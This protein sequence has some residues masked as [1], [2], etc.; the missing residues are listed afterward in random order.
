MNVV[1]N[2]AY[3]VRN[4]KLQYVYTIHIS[5]VHIPH[6]NTIKYYTKKKYSVEQNDTNNN[7]TTTRKENISSNGKCKK[8]ER[9]K[10]QEYSE[11]L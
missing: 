4:I 9:K 2:I 1:Q 6:Y 11:N 10:Y 8:E 7:N 3:S 5:R